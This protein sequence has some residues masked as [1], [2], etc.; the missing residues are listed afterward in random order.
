MRKIAVCAYFGHQPLSEL[1][2][3]SSVDL[4]MFYEEL[5]WIAEQVPIVRL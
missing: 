5:L 4:T 3:L 2:A 1:F